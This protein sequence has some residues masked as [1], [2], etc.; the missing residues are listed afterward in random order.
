MARSLGCLS[1]CH[2]ELSGASEGCFKTGDVKAGGGER[3]REG[4]AGTS[5]SG[6]GLVVDTSLVHGSGT[7]KQNLRQAS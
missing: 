6:F 2:A 1:L 3:R 7:R 5:G 4:L